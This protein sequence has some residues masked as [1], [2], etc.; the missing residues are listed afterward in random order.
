M[1]DSLTRTQLQ[2]AI[3]ELRRELAETRKRS[4]VV[5][6]LIAG[7]LDILRG[8]HSIETTA[9][10]TAADWGARPES[11]ELVPEEP[12][13]PDELAGDAELGSQV[14]KEIGRP[15]TPPAEVG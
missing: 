10:L 8:A 11:A 14:G 5:E 12:D 2:A 13:D 9:D 4:E 3:D 15:R 6:T 1:D 7:A